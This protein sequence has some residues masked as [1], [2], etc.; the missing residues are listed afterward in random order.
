MCG[1]DQGTGPGVVVFGRSV[2]LGDRSVGATCR[3][4]RPLLAQVKYGIM[5]YDKTSLC[6]TSPSGKVSAMST[7]RYSKITIRQPQ[8]LKT[9]IARAAALRGMT[10]TS[11]INGMLEIAADRTIDRIQTRELS[12]RDSDILLEMLRKPPAPNAAL[13]KAAKRL[14][15]ID[16]E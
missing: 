16:R 13:K 11:F 10:V 1:E 8:P 4:G 6:V 3:V 9:K 7:V 12:D 2:A 14:R 5:P 15:G